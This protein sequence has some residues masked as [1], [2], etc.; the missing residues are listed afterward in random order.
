MTELLL[1][2]EVLISRIS[3]LTTEKVNILP[4]LAASLSHS[5]TVQLTTTLKDLI[6]YNFPDC[7]SSLLYDVRRLLGTEDVRELRQ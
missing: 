7:W 1:N 3:A 4:L 6:A 2:L 5:I